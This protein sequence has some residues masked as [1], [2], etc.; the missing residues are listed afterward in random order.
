[1]SLCRL[2]LGLNRAGRN[3]EAGGAQIQLLHQ[4]S[5]AACSRFG[6]R[7]PRLA[8][9]MPAP[10]PPSPCTAPPGSVGPPGRTLGSQHAP[11][12]LLLLAG[13]RL[14]LYPPGC[15]PLH[16]RRRLL[17]LPPAQS[18][19]AAKCWT[20]CLGCGCRYSGGCSVSPGWD[21]R[22]LQF[23][24]TSGQRVRSKRVKQ[25]AGRQAGKP[26]GGRGGWA[27]RGRGGRAGGG[28][29]PAAPYIDLS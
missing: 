15:T 18:S 5:P 2:T 9:R 21:C 17:A 29:L 28:R 20:H 10:P 8:P 6:G 16:H 11:R 23:N 14:R 19:S 7:R 22:G 13:G 1:M 24:L 26:A 12:P 4:N 25:Q 3:G 27:G